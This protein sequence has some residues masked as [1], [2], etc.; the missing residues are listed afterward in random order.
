MA[1]FVHQTSRSLLFIVAFLLI[2]GCCFGA[3]DEE[4]HKPL[5][6]SS[7]DDNDSPK[8]GINKSFVPYKS[9]LFYVLIGITVFLIVLLCI[10]VALVALLCYRRRRSRDTINGEAEFAA[11][12]NSVASGAK[13]A[14]VSPTNTMETA[15][16]KDSRWVPSSLLS[17]ASTKMPS[18]FLSKASTKMPSSFLSKA[19]TKK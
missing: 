17:K 4:P 16:K 1:S 6:K 5:S 2:I 11:T 18:S 14:R 15:S 10:I 8:S 19:S 12:S 7:S 13:G 9:M 3:D